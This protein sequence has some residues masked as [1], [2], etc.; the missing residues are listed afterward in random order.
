L[1]EYAL[2]NSNAA[3]I[4]RFSEGYDGADADNALLAIAKHMGAGQARCVK[5]LLLDFTQVESMTLRDTD[6]ARR[7]LFF[8]QIG[9]ALDFTG[10]NLERHLAQLNAFRVEP[11]ADQVR[12]VFWERLHRIGEARALPF[13]LTTISASDITAVLIQAGVPGDEL[14]NICWQVLDHPGASIL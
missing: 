7:A 3:L 4:I 5:T 1:N 14:T 11:V 8:S 13:S 6:V 9:Q 2:L 12:A 10:S